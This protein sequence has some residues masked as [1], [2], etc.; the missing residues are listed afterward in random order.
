M[1]NVEFEGILNGTQEI[2]VRQATEKKAHGES[3]NRKAMFSFD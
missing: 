2:Q 1:V 3:E